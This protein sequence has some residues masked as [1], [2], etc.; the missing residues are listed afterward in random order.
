MLL[1]PLSAQYPA[2]A[3][4]DSPFPPSSHPQPGWTN[5]AQSVKWGSEADESMEWRIWYCFLE[6]PATAE[7]Y[8]IKKYFFLNQEFPGRGSML[9]RNLVI[10]SC[11]TIQLV[12]YQIFRKKLNF[13]KKTSYFLEKF[14][15][16]KSFVWLHFVLPALFV[17]K[18]SYL[19]LSRIC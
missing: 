6:I 16:K 5:R 14:K 10:S 13:I 3:Q 9:I 8:L 17:N 2:H 12:A 1:S 19:F 18:Q 7:L 4:D 15:M 11:F